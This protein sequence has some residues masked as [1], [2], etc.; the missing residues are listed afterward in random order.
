M[1]RRFRFIIAD[2]QDARKVSLSPSAVNGCV[3]MIHLISETL[4]YP[5]EIR[6]SL[7]PHLFY[8]SDRTIEVDPLAYLN[9]L[10]Q[11]PVVKIFD[12]PTPAELPESDYQYTALLIWNGKS[13]LVQFDSLNFLLGVKAVCNG[14][15]VSIDD[16]VKNL[17]EKVS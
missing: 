4:R 6:K 11:S 3:S 9:S 7:L 14:Y 17:A 8:V 16:V 13:A 1:H 10:I 2:R 5:E 12:T 15:S